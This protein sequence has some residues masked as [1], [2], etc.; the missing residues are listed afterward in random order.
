MT[1]GKLREK[2]TLGEGSERSCVKSTLGGDPPRT[3]RDAV[4]QSAS[5]AY[6]ATS[7]R[8]VRPERCVSRKVRVPKGA[9]DGCQRPICRKGILKVPS[10]GDLHSS[11]W[12]QWSLPSI[13]DPGERRLPRFSIMQGLERTFEL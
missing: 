6:A 3:K 12:D 9:P 13:G 2:S 8:K 1:V 7:P 5:T 4:P 10:E 11:C